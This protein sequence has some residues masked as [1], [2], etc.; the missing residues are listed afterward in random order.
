MVCAFAWSHALLILVETHGDPG[1][2]GLDARLIERLALDHV[3]GQVHFPVRGFHRG[4]VDL[5]VA[6]RGMRISGP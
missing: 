1:R 5:T 3:D 2:A 6:L 4:E